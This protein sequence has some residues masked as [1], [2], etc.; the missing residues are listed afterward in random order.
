MR[1]HLWCV[2]KKEWNRWVWDR[3]V[4]MQDTYNNHNNKS[5]QTYNIA[6]LC[7]LHRFTLKIESTLGKV[8]ALWS[9]I[10]PPP[11][12][13][14]NCEGYAVDCKQKSRLTDN[15]YLR[16]YNCP[17]SWAYCTVLSKPKNYTAKNIKIRIKYLIH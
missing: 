3:S 17:Y 9:P 11:P 4:S 5:P 16:Y 15:F 8:E 7:S 14:E 12:K 13:G 2:K 6:S 1:Y 10:L